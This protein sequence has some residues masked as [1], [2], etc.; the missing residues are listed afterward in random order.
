MAKKKNKED[1]SNTSDSKAV[2]NGED[3]DL[4]S[5]FGEFT[6]P[7]GDTYIGNFCAHRSGVVWREGH[8]IYTTRDG[9]VYQG[10]WSDDKLLD[11]R[12]VMITYP[13]GVQYHGPL[14]KNKYHGPGTY[15]LESNMNISC[16]FEG[17]KPVGT[18]TLI[19]CQGKLWRGTAEENSAILLPENVFYLNLNEY[20]GRGVSKHPIDI[21]DMHP[22][23]SKCS[24]DEEEELPDKEWEKIIFAKSKLTENDVDFTD[25]SWWKNYENYR[26]KYDEIMDKLNEGISLNNDDYMWIDRFNSFKRAQQLR[27]DGK[28]TAWKTEEEKVFALNERYQS[29]DFQESCPGVSVF[30]PRREK[31]IKRDAKDL[32][33]DASDQVIGDNKTNII[34]VNSFGEITNP[35]ME[36][37]K[38]QNSLSGVESTPIGSRSKIPQPQDDAAAHCGVSAEYLKTHPSLRR[39]IHPSF[40]D[41]KEEPLHFTKFREEIL[42]ERKRVIKSEE[43]YQ[44]DKAQKS[45]SKEPFES[46]DKLDRVS[47]TMSKDTDSIRDSTVDTSP[48]SPTDLRAKIQM[49]VKECVEQFLA[50]R[51][52]KVER[53]RRTGERLPA[54]PHTHDIVAHTESI[55][56]IPRKILL[57]NEPS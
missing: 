24:S 51:K 20:K 12:E 36:T 30:Y 2:D 32:A 26:Q 16:Q 14:V 17:N 38:T 47:M 57:E 33:T 4:H 8:G 1:A 41:D 50:S 35:S 37:S 3:P 34:Y 48:T 43:K 22:P 49:K 28:L 39:V 56:G 11:N 29:K 31:I 45:A 9:Q 42:L 25:C 15:I 10:Q 5:G 54:K 55:T 18:V 52:T 19:D 44:A 6:L 27:K 23:A 7:N 21:S 53:M 40:N 13:S 46:K